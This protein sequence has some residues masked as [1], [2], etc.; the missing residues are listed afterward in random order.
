[1]SDTI[2]SALI[3]LIDTIFNLYL[4][5]LVVR[6]ILVWVRA[7]YFNPF[8]QFILRFTDIVVKPIRKI[9][10]NIKNIE[11]ASVILVLVIET[12]KFLLVAMISFGMPSFLGIPVL[13][14]ADSIALVLQ[15][16]TYAIFLQVILSF[17]QPNSPMMAVVTR[18]N[19]PI[20]RPLHQ[21]IPP[22]GGFDIT[23]IPALIGL[24][25]LNIILVAPLMSLGQGIA[26][27]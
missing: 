7:D 27:G 15:T 1:M 13:A 20:M 24:Q 9:I 5:L 14:I 25:L 3:F 21:L 23:P 18:F 4:F 19:S 26:F 8:T 16:F 10:P 6:L 22:I 12:I 11:T 2:R 17:V